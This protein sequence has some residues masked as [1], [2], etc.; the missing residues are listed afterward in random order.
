MTPLSLHSQTWAQTAN[1]NP[2]T[3]RRSAPTL[4]LLVSQH[5]FQNIKN[6]FY[7]STRLD[8]EVPEYFMYSRLKLF[9]YNT[10]KYKVAG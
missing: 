5:N 1:D 8:Q 4:V 7:A 10:Y 3:S 9:L 2:G 6:S